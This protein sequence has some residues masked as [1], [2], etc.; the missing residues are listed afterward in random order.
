MAKG[1]ITRKDIIEDE[2]LRWGDDYAKQMKKAVSAQNQLLK[3]AKELL[4]I[5]SQYTK[6]KGQSEFITLKQQEALATQTAIDAIKKEEA[7]M[8][9]AEKVK[10]AKL[11]T[12]KEELALQA[13]QDRQTKSSTR[14]TLEERIQQ[15]EAN[16]VLKQ[17]I[18]EKM[19]MVGAYQKLNA[20]R[21]EA[22]K[23]LA[24]LLS[25]EVRNNAEI[26]KA[27][28]EFDALDARVKKV[29]A[30]IRNYTKNIG[31]YSSAFSGLSSNLS[32]LMGAFG[33]VGG[34]TAFANITRNIFETTRETQAL[35][36][37]LKQVTRTQDE[38]AESQEFLIRISEAYGIEINGLTRSYTGFL[39]ASQNAIDS[40]AIS[41]QQ[42]KEIFES[43]SKAAGAMGLSVD[44]QQGAFLALQQM[45][46]KGNVQAEEIRGQLAERLPGAFG[47]LARSMGV[48]EMELNKL[49]KDGKVLA[50]EVL[51][52]FA[53]ELEKA[54][55]VENLN[56]VESLNAETS[57]LSNTWV[58]FVRELN[59][60]DGTVTRVFGSLIAQLR[61]AVSAWKFVFASS[62]S[63]NKILNQEISEKYY[64]DTKSS[65]NSKIN[66]ALNERET[67]LINIE[68]LKKISAKST[69]EETQKEIAALEERL[70]A[71]DINF[72]QESAIVKDKAKIR[73]EEIQAFLAEN[74]NAA[75][76][77]ELE[78]Y[79]LTQ[80]KKPYEKPFSI[81]YDPND[82]NQEIEFKIK[83]NNEAIREYNKQISAGNGAMKALNEIIN[84]TAESSAKKTKAVVE[85]SKAE[86]AAI[87][88][89][90][91]KYID[92]L[93]NAEN[94]DF[95]LREN[96][97]KYSSAFN[98]D[99]LKDEKST[100]DEKMDALYENSQ[101]DR[102][103]S[104]E[105]LEHKLKIMALEKEG[106]EKLSKDEFNIYIKGADA[107]I[108]L[109]LS[110][111]LAVE[112]MTTA[113]KIFYEKM[114]NDKIVIAK[115][116]AEEQQKIIDAQVA[117]YQK[118]IDSAKAEQERQINEAIEFENKKFKASN[119]LE[120]MNMRD[121]E[122][123]IL[124]HENK[125]L[126]I[127]KKFALDAL[128]IQIDGLESE[129]ATNDAKEAKEQVSG[130]VRK[131]LAED[132]QAAKTEY[133]NLEKENYIENIDEK[134]QR[135]AEFS[136]AVLEASQN[137]ASALMDLANAVME[138]RIQN[139]DNEIQRN[140]EF[141]NRQIELAG[142]D[143]A[144]KKLLEEQAEKDRKKLEDKKRKEQIKQAIMNKA[145]SIVEIGFATAQGIMQ[146]YAQLGPIAGNAGALL[147]GILGGIQTAAVLATP[148]PKYKDGRIGGP[149]EFAEVGDGYVSEVIQ[150]ADGRAFLTPN[151][152]TLTYLE[153]GDNV[154]SNVKEFNRLQRASFMA[155][156]EMENS[157]ANDY[158]ASLIF[159][160]T[161]GKELLEEMILTRKAIE[162]NK[163][164][165]TVNNM[166]KID[167]GHELWKYKNTNWNA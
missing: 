78:N 13:Q 80:Q 113:E 14:L 112:K 26:R 148:I 142:N 93:K 52:A 48:T 154:Y 101:F 110:E 121:R 125:I 23:T 1:T 66:Q 127:K 136:E 100:L 31:N 39:A 72:K 74:S 50:A 61:E 27:Q 29:D 162:K 158:Q 145:L 129:L 105:T 164:N 67:I 17:A 96:R 82:P 25:A 19:G 95:Q 117:V 54:Y 15:Q 5:Y 46:S 71:V 21:N 28:K 84:Q 69:K 56:R 151:R 79:K 77:L 12:M 47:I 30:S 98:D 138:T 133:S 49:L 86:I 9:S 2:A 97:F 53:K 11:Q 16:K 122:S 83:K 155:S 159:E 89:A 3:S 7:A 63:K 124:D 38:F 140:D 44:Q 57:R 153:K 118:N 167:M 68:K 143:A 104:S 32:N 128:K 102:A 126:E 64:N 37:A 152:P 58:D 36:L 141:Y 81:G 34:V 144:Q 160:K 59:S 165:V 91:K 40:G 94:D 114:Q 130:E 85:L 73:R 109:I 161:Y 150:K 137:V 70:R 33:I 107:R 92:S 62:S 22:Q 45:I 4:T 156:L 60:G 10:K 6:I 75:K 65:I 131:K 51:P 76:K 106:L 90:R 99:I 18:L 123:A 108:K 41:A 119:D 132:L 166:L 35:D 87:E 42:I 20:R 163:T 88:R 157:K 8:L 135:E 147:V 134:T 115:R 55:G 116:T 149:A 139:I 111:Q 24:N 120:S 146:S 103:L 43:V